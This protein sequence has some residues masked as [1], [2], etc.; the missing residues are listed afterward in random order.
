MHCRVGTLRDVFRIY[1]AG[2]MSCSVAVLV[3]DTLTCP[4]TLNKKY[5]VY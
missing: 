3:L 2:V 1:T 5:D 4:R